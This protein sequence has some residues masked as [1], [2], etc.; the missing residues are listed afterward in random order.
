LLLSVG[1]EAVNDVVLTAEWRTYGE[2]DAVLLIADGV[3]RQA[4]TATPRVLHDF[5][6]VLLPNID[7]WQGDR[8]IDPSMRDPEAWGTLVMS[9]HESGEVIDV[10]PERFWAGVHIWFRSRG[11]DYDTP[12]PEE[13]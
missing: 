10:D 9:R 8:L 5:L 6:T 2:F 13:A 7:H 3:V 1:L 11:V 4:F 12:I